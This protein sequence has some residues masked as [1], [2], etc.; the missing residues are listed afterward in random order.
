MRRSTDTHPR[1]S[2]EMMESSRVLEVEVLAMRTEN[3]QS[4]RTTS[5]RVAAAIAVAA[6]LVFGTL[7]LGDSL[8]TASSAPHGIVPLGSTNEGG[9]GSS[10]GPA[11]GIVDIVAGACAGAVTEATYERLASRITLTKDSK[12]VAQWEIYGEQRISWVEPIGT[13]S[14]RSNQITLP[15]SVRLVVSSSRVAEVRL[16]PACK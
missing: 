7:Q 2:R 16:M 9:A 14:A 1:E 13:Y 12:V 10:R 8:A 15:R 11:T 6:A 4:R 5:S 3:Q